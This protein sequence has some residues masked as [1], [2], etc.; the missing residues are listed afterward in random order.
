MYLIF[1]TETTG[2]PRNYNA[3][4]SDLDNWPRLVQIAWQL[5][6][7]GGKLLSQ[8]SYIVKP[9][10]FT[11]PFNSERIHGIS[12]ALAM[13]QGHSLAEVMAAFS[14]DLA[15]SSM[16]VGHNIEFDINIVGAEYLRLGLANALQGWP[17]LDTKEASTAYCAIPGGKGGKFKWPTLTELHHKLFGNG[18]QDAHDAAFDVD[19]TAK[20][21]FGLIKV[22]VVPPAESIL[23][24]GVEYEAPK[25]DTANFAK[26]AKNQGKRTRAKVPIADIKGTF[27]H[28]HVHSQFSVLQAVP[29]IPDLIK[30]AKEH[31]MPA[32]ALTDLGNMFG[33][34]KFVQEALKNDIKPIVGCEFYVAEERR[35]LQFTKDNPDK[36]FNQVLL[37]KN[38]D[39]FLNLAKLASLAFTEGNYGLYPRIDK[40]L[41]REYRKD[42]IALSGGMNG[43]VPSLILNVG[44]H[45]AEEAFKWWLDTFEDDF[46]VELMRH[47]LE[48]EDRVN[49]VLL[50]FAD[51]YG[52]KVIASNDVYYLK[53]EDAE[54]HDILLCVR[55]GE[56]KDTP[57]GRG[58]GF[59]FGFPNNNYYFRSQEEMKKLFADV[60][61]A[62]ENIDELVGKIEPFQLS[63]DVLLPVFDIPEEFKDPKDEEDGGKRG[64]N[65]Y[66]RYLA[67]E[68]AKKR[69]G[70]ITDEIKERLDF[71]LATIERTG[72]P[73]YFLIVQDFTNKAREMGVSVGPGRGSA[74]GSAVA[75][76]VGI[77]NVDPIK[78]DLLFE[79][80]LNPDRV[81]MP[82]ID[83]DFD[84]VGRAK[85]I[86][87]V[88]EKYGKNQV[89]QIVT[90]GTMAA[91][92]AIRDCGRVLDLPLHE[93][94]ELAKLIPDKPIGINIKQ[95]LEAEPKLKKIRDSDT[96][97]GEV[98]RKAE[99]LEGSMRNTGVHACG[100]IITPDDIQKFIPVATAKDS[101]LVV[102]QYDNSIVESAGLLKM[103]FLGLKTLTIINDALALIKKKHGIEIDIENVDL[104]DAKTF[105]LFSQ[106]LTLGLFQFESP[107]MQKH[108]K[109]LK[110]DKF[111]D[112][113]AMNALYRPG[114]MEYIPEYVA[115]KH[116][117]S[118]IQ[119][120]TPEMAPYLQETYGI[121]VYQEQVML[122]SQ[123]LA[124]FT[125]GQADKLRKAMGKKQKAV[126]DEMQED[127]LKGCKENNLDLKVCKKIWTDWEAFASY[128]FNKSHSTC[129]AFIA[130]QTGYLKAHYPA[131][132]MASVLTHN[133]NDI[134]KLTRYMK[135][136]KDI[137]INVLGPH[138]NE[139][140]I[141][142]EVND[143]GEIR[144]GLGA[145]KGAGEAAVSMIIEE[146]EKK[147][148]FKD[149]YDFALRM[150]GKGLNKRT[151][152]A[153]AESG[154]FDCFT[155]FH[156]RQYMEAPE[157]DQNLIEKAVK[158]AQKV[159]EDEDS[160]QISLFGGS[161]GMEIPRPRVAPLEPWHDLVKLRKERDVIGLYI[162][163]HP[164]DQFKLEMQYFCNNSLSALANLQ[165]LEGKTLK[166]AGIVSEAKHLVSNKNNKPFGFFTLEDYNGEYE[167]RLFDQ[168]Y[169]HYKAMM[170]KGWYLHITCTSEPSRYR[171]G[172]YQ[173]KIK[174]IEL[175]SNMWDTKAK[176]LLVNV[177]LERIDERF[178]M[179]LD[180]LHKEHHGDKPLKIRIHSENL[181]QVDVMARKLCIKLEPRSVRRVKAIFKSKPEVL[182]Q[183]N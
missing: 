120:D 28:L 12:T 139:S 53:K 173:L 29:P 69:Y 6:D 130:F 60:P 63:R 163:G 78:Y 42:V 41:I 113:I 124:G 110:P 7:A 13:E 138:V 62:I 88:I 40:E 92:S 115:R 18:F 95:A 5:H 161:G 133:L 3:P 55:D 165:D 106:G 111:E 67:F 87:Y 119:Y 101:D 174:K 125:K 48:A 168:D 23:A 76:C 102:T 182:F 49:E 82:D 153:L 85:V 32:V 152:E 155:E 118:P 128:A 30:A 33:T 158:Y 109:A 86:D 142:F 91:K 96:L 170:E 156:R 135:A 80:F 105:E 129:Y 157:G 116:G 37:A 65:A 175:L 26:K 10:G 172:E 56:K 34:F 47:G 160:A 108:L 54:A 68:G 44:E 151:L 94:N 75:Y 64:E 98:V 61:E 83:I 59:R 70:E 74:A 122:L 143:K 146:R 89:A 179:E 25:L 36:R 181:R 90:Y 8:H 11:I 57:I 180:A 144:F 147:G 123:A 149:F 134:K 117:K 183:E 77:T 2:L 24:N 35:K 132:F 22:G 99:T 137:D 164:L 84:D 15:G 52:V 17:L 73:G 50:E 71:E 114:P 31:N 27:C 58:R 150:H 178:L 79:R 145:I 4:V 107:G 140:G 9:E 46:Y 16:V 39:G 176:G 121:T 72:Y 19:A 148:P 127:F 131:E 169:L 166:V 154:A 136:A 93:T 38:K 66:L 171:P 162:S 20:C 103:D 159:K 81:S 177:A 14:A 112:L 126:L 104:T 97:H 51:K 141:H 21:F 45:Q 1:D 100:V 167:F 43:E